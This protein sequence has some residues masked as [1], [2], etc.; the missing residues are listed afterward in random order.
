MEQ[1]NTVPSLKVSAVQFPMG[2]QIS[3]AKFLEKVEGFIKEASSIA[4]DLVVFPELI[5][6]EL[7]DWKLSKEDIPAL[8][9]LAEDF[10]PRFLK[11]ISEKSKEYKLAI[12]GGSTPRFH[13]EASRRIGIAQPPAQQTNRV[14]LN[15]APLALPTGELFLQDKLFITPP[16]LDWGWSTG[17]Q[18][19][20]LDLPW[21]RT[22]IL[23]CFDCEFPAI[24]NCLAEIQPDLILV[25]SWTGSRHGLNRV[26]WTARARA[27]EHYAFVIKTG[28]VPLENSKK[29]H[30]GQAGIYSPQDDRFPVEAIIGIENQ[31][32]IVTARLDLGTLRKQKPTTGYHPGRIQG[33]AGINPELV[34]RAAQRTISAASSAS[35]P[36]GSV[37]L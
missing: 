35:T 18:I 13:I 29:S 4:S 22:V 32:G 28:T 31:P 21:G 17:Q 34:F 19:Q 36:S 8:E 2:G 23:I 7:I 26:D 14:L 24:S 25:P 27:I 33:E 3:E 12:L 30:F 11:W 37:N 10:S 9:A 6:T 5:T 15:T 1:Q 20:V 16:E